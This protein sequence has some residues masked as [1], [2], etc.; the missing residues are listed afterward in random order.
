MR[1]S[2]QEAFIKLILDSSKYAKVTIASSDLSM[3][4]N[5]LKKYEL[6]QIEEAVLAHLDNP[7]DEFNLMPKAHHISGYIKSKQ[8]PPI[9]LL[10]TRA[11]ELVLRRIKDEGRYTSQVFE[12]GLLHAVIES[13]GGW[14]KLCLTE[15]K[16]L[17]RKEFKELYISYARNPP[18]RMPDFL[19]GVFDAPALTH[20]AANDQ[21]RISQF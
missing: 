9:E 20:E 8:Q 2:D 19:P 16:Y 14:V 15:E 13:L 7:P 6:G 1:D 21:P 5:L 11:W 3:Y 10:A 17:P 12:D 18:G 4:W